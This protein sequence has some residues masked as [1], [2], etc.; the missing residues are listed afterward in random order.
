[1]WRYECLRKLLCEMIG[2]FKTHSSN[3]DLTLSCECLFNLSTP[4]LNT[5][6][7]TLPHIH[8]WTHLQQH[9]SCECYINFNSFHELHLHPPAINCISL[10][11]IMCWYD[12]IDFGEVEIKF[13]SLPLIFHVT[14]LL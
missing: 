9:I 11:D 4:L 5:R 8:K 7:L 10:W 2:V 13:C 14:F 6:T 1:M 3:N 12:F